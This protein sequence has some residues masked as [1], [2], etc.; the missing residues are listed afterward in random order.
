L[1][2]LLLNAA[3]DVAVSLVDAIDVDVVFDVACAVVDT[4]DVDDVVA[5]A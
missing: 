5:V 3:V 2:L 4:A 1:R